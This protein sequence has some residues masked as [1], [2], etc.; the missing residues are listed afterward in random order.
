ME[1]N[2]NLP[3]YWKAVIEQREME[4]EVKKKQEEEDGRDNHSNGK[5]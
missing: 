1:T 3:E 2:A 4:E 5:K